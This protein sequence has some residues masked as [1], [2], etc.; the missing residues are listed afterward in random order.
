MYIYIYI[1]I[2]VY[3]C[4]YIY[5]YSL[6][7]LSA[8]RARLSSGLRPVSPD[9]SSETPGFHISY[10]IKLFSLISVKRARW[11][12]IGIDYRHLVPRCLLRLYNQVV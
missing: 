6:I 2:H 5:I 7:S 12:M 9:P 3:V 11:Q 10:I 4:I 8:T 1:H